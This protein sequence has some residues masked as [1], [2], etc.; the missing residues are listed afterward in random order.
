MTSFP[1]IKPATARHKL[2]EARAVLEKHLGNRGMIEHITCKLERLSPMARDP[3]S[4]GIEKT[5]LKQWPWASG[6]EYKAR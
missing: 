1:V 2:S 4:F 3:T 6:I 5:S